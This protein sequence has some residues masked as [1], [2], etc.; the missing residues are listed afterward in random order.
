[1]G[2]QKFQKPRKESRK[3]AT[4]AMHKNRKPNKKQREMLVKLEIY[5]G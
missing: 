4:T 1:M 2:K 5:N 3:Q